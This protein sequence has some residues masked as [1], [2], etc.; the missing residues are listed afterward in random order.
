MVL[1]RFVLFFALFASFT[2]IS[3]AQ[4]TDLCAQS[5]N[6]SDREIIRQKLHKIPKL[7]LAVLVLLDDPA[8]PEKI[9]DLFTSELT[10][11][12]LLPIEPLESPAFKYQLGTQER[13]DGYRMFDQRL[14]YDT[15]SI[16][17]RLSIIKIR[18][19][20]ILKMLLTLFHELS[21][22]YFEKLIHR[23]P[24]MF[25]KIPMRYLKNNFYKQ[26]SENYAD[27]MEEYYIKNMPKGY[28]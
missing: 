12:F 10:D 7:Q 2:W 19:D 14:F 11:P 21:H 26:E 22:Q 8:V 18:D 6:R 17:S 9:K 28:L 4:S 20:D 5:L 15:H 25:D 24:V 27:R 13:I 1:I 3:H 23:Y 16:K